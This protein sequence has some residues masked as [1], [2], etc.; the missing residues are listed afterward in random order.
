[1]S[2][3]HSSET[4]SSAG[5]RVD[6]WLWATRFFKTRALAKQAVEGG[7]IDVNG[8]TVAKAA[9]ML[10]VG[11]RLHIA[12]GEERFE[13]A[14]TGLPEQRGSATIARTYFEE[15]L[16]SRTARVAAAE[17]RRL[18]NAGYSRPATKPD[19]RARRLLRALGDIDMT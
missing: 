7:K 3:Q 18:E 14:V 9:K 19:K 17:R 5:V 6:V 15:T 12:R 11:D 10:H 16:E 4:D 8:S 13:I 1:M 2:S